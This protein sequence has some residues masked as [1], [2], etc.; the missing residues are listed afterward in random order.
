MD[1]QRRITLYLFGILLG[2][3][4]AYW[5]YGER[6]T[7]GA[8]LPENRIRQRL[9]STLVKAA[10]PAQEQMAAWPTDLAALRAAMPTASVDLKASERTPDSIH[11]HLSL[12][13]GE[14]PA[15]LVV[16]VLRDPDQDSTATLRT[17]LPGVDRR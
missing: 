4:M 12:S 15:R 7:G 1:L 14:R 6:L 2:C 9:Q 16:S 3:G 8:W 11:Y 17:L 10:G 13:L 5:F